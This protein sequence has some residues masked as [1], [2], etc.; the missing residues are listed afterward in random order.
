MVGVSGDSDGHD[1]TGPEPEPHV[2]RETGVRSVQVAREGEPQISQRAQR[3]GCGLSS[4]DTTSHPPDPVHLAPFGYRRTVSMTGLV[5]PVKKFGET[6]K[7]GLGDR[8]YDEV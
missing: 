2:K 4:S 6:G 1:P 3:C 8:G 7:N 5:W